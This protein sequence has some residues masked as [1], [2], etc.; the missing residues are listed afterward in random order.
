MG[1]GEETAMISPEILRVVVAIF[2]FGVG[3]TV[4]SYCSYKGLNEELEKSG[5]RLEDWL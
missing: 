2:I 1:S 4:G 3:F 5:I